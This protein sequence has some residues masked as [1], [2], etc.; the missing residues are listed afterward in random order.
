M[1]KRYE[2]YENYD[3][4]GMEEE[5]NGDYV[6]FNK[7]KQELLNLKRYDFFYFGGEI[8]SMEEEKNGDYIKFEDIEKLLE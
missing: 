3:D 2:M 8:D 5:V 1:I 6:K 4:F 7:L